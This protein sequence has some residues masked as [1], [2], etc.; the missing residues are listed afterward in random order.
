MNWMKVKV[1][2][3]ILFALINIMLI[4]I[5]IAWKRDDGVLTENSVED[6]YQ[7]MI[8]NRINVSRD[9]IDIQLSEMK[10][11]DVIP[12]SSSESGFLEKLSGKAVLLPEGTYVYDNS[13][14]MVYENFVQFENDG[15]ISGKTEEDKAEENIRKY[16]K[17]FGFDFKNAGLE[18]SEHTDE[19][20][21]LTYSQIYDGYKIFGAGA[22]VLMEG[23]TVKSASVFWNEIPDSHYQSIETISFAEALLNFAGDKTRGKKGYKVESI[24]MGYSVESQ[25]GRVSESQMI[26]C[27]RITTDIGS[28]FFYDA[29]SLE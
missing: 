25:D 26:P 9:F 17:K 27:I 6:I 8:D 28:S 20:L 24:E 4:S 18:K 19:G 29:R 13:R 14:V 2:L 3:I 10:I 1:I 15:E 22:T 16:F 12:I 23:N 7:I 11:T 5:L 21:K